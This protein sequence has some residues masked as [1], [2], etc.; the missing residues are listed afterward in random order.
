MDLVHSFPARLSELVWGAPLMGLLLIVGLCITF[1]TR[2]VQV[3]KLG[4]S[5][6]HVWNSAKAPA[7]EGGVSSFQALCTALAATIGTGNLVGV[8]GAI[9]LGGPGA[10]FWMWVSAFFGMCTKYAEIALAMKY[11]EKDENG[12]Y[13]GGP[14]YYI[15]NGLGKSWTWLAVIFAILGGL[16]CF[17]T[18]YFTVYRKLDKTSKTA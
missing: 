1:A 7:K 12:A 8:A 3:R 4:A 5:L 6:R 15:R 9:T 11:R 13:H 2:F 17:T 14:M 10:V 18:M 16:A